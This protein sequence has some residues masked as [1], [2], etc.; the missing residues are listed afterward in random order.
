MTQTARKQS[1][2]A[3]KTHHDR[4]L[5][6]KTAKPRR[7]RRTA[8]RALREAPHAALPRFVKPCLAT[9]V[10]KAPQGER[11]EHE[12]KFDGYRIQA[13]LDHGKV[14]LLTRKGLDWTDKFR[15]VAQSVG[16]LKA[17]TALLDGELVVE[18]DKGISRFSLLQQ[19]L[20]GSRHGR[21]VLYAFDLMHLDGN[22]LQGQPLSARK[23][24]L[25]KLIRRG[26]GRHLQ[27]SRSLARPGPALL[28]KACKMGLEGIISKL[29][30]KPYR[31]GRG[32]DWVKTK[33]SDRQE[34]VVAGFAPS[35]A[36]AHAVGA[37]VLAYHDHGKLHYAG[38]VGT[39]FTHDTAHRLYR[40]L[41]SRARKTPPF[42]PVPK[43]EKGRRK[44]VWVEPN[45]VVEVDFHGW[46]HGD[47]VRQASFQGVRHDKPAKDG[48]ALMADKKRTRAQR[49]KA[50]GRRASA[51]AGKVRLSHPDR[52]YWEDAGVTKEQLSDYYGKVWKWMRPHVVGRAIALVRCPEGA[53]MGQCF[54]QKHARAGIPTEFLH[55]VPEKG[56]QI[57]S[58]EDLDGLIALVQGGALEIH[59]RGS[60]IDDR[61][62]ADRL[63]FDLDPGPGMGFGD[64]VEGAREARDRLKR[65]KLK[66]YVKTTGG[67]GLHVVVPI[68]PAPWAVAKKFAQTLALSMAK[69]EPG[70]YLASAS[71]ARRDKRI[72]VDWLRNSRE[73]TAI[74]PY[75]TRARDGAPVAAPVAWSELGRLKSANHYTVR[76]MVQ[77]L[78]R[79]RR[80]PWAGM[81]RVKQQLP[82]FR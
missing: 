16:K 56:S 79:L 78:K 53:D 44:P 30:D 61:E 18:D 5:M 49:R 28:K 23:A 14:K 73:A 17:K 24:A 80:D 19:D 46:T 55:L 64:V 81:A 41:N 76:N 43:D 27:L 60:T 51:M 3:S 21:M 8:D 39:G 13:R 50:R 32:H 6:R 70:R 40:T 34:L 36:D 4:R 54:F 31:S 37:L 69:D 20:S 66:S 29:K 22:D 75:S 12:I 74:A 57:I 33:C 58:V 10:D 62:R 59:L 1:K 77:R 25:A 68:A 11:W 67:K 71:K 7:S 15:S 65:I 9:L 63:V 2:A 35:S 48:N 82:E 52:I 26:H 38:R 42:K 45:M 47:R 72:F